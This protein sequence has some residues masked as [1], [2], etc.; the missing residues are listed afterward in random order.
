[1]VPAGPGD[2]AD[3]GRVHAEAWQESHRSFCAEAFV[4]LHTA[5]RQAQ[6][7]S[8]K[9]AH[10]AQLYLLKVDSRAVGVVSVTG[11]LIEDLYI[12][13]DCQNRGLGTALLRY[14]VRRCEGKPTLWILENNAGAER[15][16]RREGFVP[17]GR[18]NNITDGLDEV[19]FELQHTE[20]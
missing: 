13:P 16:Y 19:E 11:S 12:L 1:M 5:Q 14:A 3:A 18:R 8:D 17:T 9:L 15:L 4:A 20:G 6:Y 10:G 2:I 7:L